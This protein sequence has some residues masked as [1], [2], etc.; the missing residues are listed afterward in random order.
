LSAG[1]DKK[2]ILWDLTIEKS[3]HVFEVGSEVTSV[4]FIPNVILVT[5]NSQII[6]FLLVLLMV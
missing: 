4:V 1:L 2:V 3:I 5:T 6:T